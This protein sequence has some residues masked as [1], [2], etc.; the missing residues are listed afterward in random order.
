[1]TLKDWLEREGLAPASFAPRIGRSS[2]A[3]RRYA[4]G[5][6]IPD[7]ETMPLI[8]AATAGDVTANDFFGIALPIVAAA[9]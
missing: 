5:E 4:S 8:A 3:V 1:M 2:E 6:R 7:R 9:A